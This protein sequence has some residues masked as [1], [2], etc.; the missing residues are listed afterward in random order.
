M[1]QASGLNQWI[2]VFTKRTN[3]G[4]DERVYA[5]A[6]GDDELVDN[7]KTAIA[8]CKIRHGLTS[9]PRARLASSYYAE[10]HATA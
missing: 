10:H 5:T 2:V 8:N 6:Y 3:H 9:R 7:I 1:E 4:Q